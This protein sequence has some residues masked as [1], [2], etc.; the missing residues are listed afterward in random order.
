[1]ILSGLA[2]IFPNFRLLSGIALLILGILML[3]SFTIDESVR[4]QITHNREEDAIK[5]LKK[6]VKM[7][8]KSEL[9]EV[10]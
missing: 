2:Y 8:G 6:A 10:S 7:N 9:T 3:W 1:M 5:T 4:W